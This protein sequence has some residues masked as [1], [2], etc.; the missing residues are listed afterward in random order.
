MCIG[1][2]SLATTNAARSDSAIVCRN[3]VAPLDRRPGLCVAAVVSAGPPSTIYSKPN[4]SFSGRTNCPKF[5]AGLALF[6][7]EPGPRNPG[8][9]YFPALVSFKAAARSLSSTAN[10]HFTGCISH[11]KCRRQVQI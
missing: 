10:C 3:D 5:C 11:P 7:A 9:S 1:P 4:R 8:S 6:G 2:L